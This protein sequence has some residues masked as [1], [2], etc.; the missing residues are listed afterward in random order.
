MLVYVLAQDG[1]QDEW[2]VKAYLVPI[3]KIMGIL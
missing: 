3:R 2:P 1:K